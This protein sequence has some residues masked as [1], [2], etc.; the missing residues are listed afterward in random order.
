MQ[1]RWILA[2]GLLLCGG[3]VTCFGV[4]SDDGSDDV[5][6]SG[7]ER[8]D[9]SIVSYAEAEVIDWAIKDT[10]NVLTLKVKEL[11][12]K[13]EIEEDTGVPEPC[14]RL[15]ELVEN[16]SSRRIRWRLCYSELRC[17]EAILNYFNGFKTE[18]AICGCSETRCEVLQLE[19][20]WYCFNCVARSLTDVL[21][22]F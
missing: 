19:A 7:V 13:L 12:K 14:Q 9:K 21:L 3:S 8:D 10:R 1:R 4:G 11:R 6:W 22:T 18:G 5:S 17:N 16:L 2:A 20:D 15:V